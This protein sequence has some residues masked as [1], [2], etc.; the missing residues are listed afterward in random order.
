M[1]PARAWYGL[2]LLVVALAGCG[3]AGLPDASSD[4]ATSDEARPGLHLA[5]TLTDCR[6]LAVFFEVPSA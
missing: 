1:V 4:S 5:W 3:D 6:E 2:P